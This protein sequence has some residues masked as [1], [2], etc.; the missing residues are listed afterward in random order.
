[1]KTIKSLL[2][3][4]GYSNID[5]YAGLAKSLSKLAN[6]PEYSYLDD[7]IWAALRALHRLQEHSYC[8]NIWNSYNFR[9]KKDYNYLKARTAKTGELRFDS[10]EE[11]VLFY[12]N[13]GKCELMRKEDLNI[14]KDLISELLLD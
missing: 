7:Q 3:I 9:F 5:F 12:Y 10:E 8:E 1:M 2:G 11:A 6:N 13:Y 14:V 4:S